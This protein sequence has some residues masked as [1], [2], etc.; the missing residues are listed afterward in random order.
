MFDFLSG[1]AVVLRRG[2][3]SES[4]IGGWDGE[5]RVRQEMMGWRLAFAFGRVG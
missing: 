3:R 2:T 5:C 4:H 1:H